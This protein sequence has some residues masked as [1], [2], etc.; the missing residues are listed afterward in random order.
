MFTWLGTYLFV[1]VVVQFYPWFNS[2]FLLLFFYA[3]A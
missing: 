2:D 1:Y 3:N